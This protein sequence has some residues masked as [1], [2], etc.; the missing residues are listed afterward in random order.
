MM[1]SSKESQNQFLATFELNQANG[2]AQ[3]PSWLRRLRKTAIGCFQEL[4][5][6]TTRDE[7]WKYTSVEPIL[8]HVFELGKGTETTA[9]PQVLLSQSF[10]EAAACRLV[11]INGHFHPALS[12]MAR[13]PAGVRV[14]SLAQAVRQGDELLEARLAQSAKHQEQTFV[15]LNTAFIED[16]AMVAVGEGCRVEEPI[17]LVFVSIPGESP[18]MSHP[19]NLIVL[20]ARSEAEIVESYV[21]LGKGAYFTNAVTELELA[22]EALLGH[23]RVQREG[24]GGLH[25]GALTARLN[26]GSRLTAHA[27]TLSGLLVRN[28]VM[29]LLDGEGSECTLNGLYVLDG[30]QHVDNHTEIEHVKPRAMS[31]ELYKG[32]LGGH[33]RGVFNGKILVHKDAQKTNARQT[34]KNLLLSEHAVVNTKPQLEIRADDVKCSHGSTIG[35]LDRDALFYFRS[36]GIGSEEAQSLLCYAFASE[37]AQRIKI[38]SMR[39]GLDNYLLAQFAKKRTPAI[40]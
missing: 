19:R 27:L 36:R 35:Q 22:E 3:S 12:S 32:V 4:G 14:A 25:V 40:L 13:L 17:F 16:G 8:S 24:D 10:A 23:C 34:N 37:V 5:F 33:G 26:R 20:Q 9:T 31:S 7:E 2:A 6:P 39:E 1:T 30:Q 38:A 28:N 15:A 18:T 21:G 11:F 29:A